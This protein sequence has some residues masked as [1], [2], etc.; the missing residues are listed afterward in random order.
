MPSETTVETGASVEERALERL[1]ASRD[2][3]RTTLARTR[4]EVQALLVARAGAGDE[5]A[6]AASELGRF[7]AP[8]IDVE[9]F[10]ALL[11]REEGFAPDEASRVA[12]ARDTLEALIRRGDDLYRA[13][14]E[15]GG[16]LAGAAVRAL[17]E[18]GRA[19]GAARVVELT[20]SGRFEAD[21]DEAWLEGL[22]PAAWTRR[23]RELAPPLVLRV[24]GADLAPAGL[25][26]LLDGGQKIVLVV[27]GEAPP[28]ALAALVTP[29][30]FVAQV[31]DP[32]ELGSLAD[33]AAP[34]VAAIVP[35]EAALFTHRPAPGAGDP[36]ALGTLTVERMPEAAP[37]RPIGG[38]SAFRQ[39]EDLRRLEA[40]ARLAAFEASGAGVNGAGTPAGPDADSRADLLAAWILRQADLG[41][42][43]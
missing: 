15:P 30:V 19:F 28:A 4:E 38:Q 39:A 11:D 21:G 18:A 36:A 13:A 33:A 2:A 37:R 20:R 6:R 3:F 22:P 40:L 29:G 24:A 32:E 43:A 26:P 16:D 1:G 17:T 41:P 35:A 31:S 12:R 7:A 27:E 10:S 5:A 42:D 8:R 9:R 25:A 23:E 14:V 34:G